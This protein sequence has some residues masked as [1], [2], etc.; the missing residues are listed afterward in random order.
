MAEVDHPLS[1]LAAEGG[2]LLDDLIQ[3]RCVE[4]EGDRSED[5]V[6]GPPASDDICI[7]GVLLVGDLNSRKVVYDCVKI[8]LHSLWLL[9]PS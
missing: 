7:E 8:M 3:Q 4:V 1:V 5:L 9:S 2:E 6:L